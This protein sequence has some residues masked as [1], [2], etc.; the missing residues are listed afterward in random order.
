MYMGSRIIHVL[1]RWHWNWSRICAP[2]TKVTANTFLINLLLILSIQKE[3]K[4]HSKHHSYLG[5]ACG[6]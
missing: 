3:T 2:H 4:S 6:A 5:C 1:M